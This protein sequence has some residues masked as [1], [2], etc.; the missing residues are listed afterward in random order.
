MGHTGQLLDTS[1]H[2]QSW[3]FRLCGNAGSLGAMPG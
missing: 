1:K 3:S 2:E